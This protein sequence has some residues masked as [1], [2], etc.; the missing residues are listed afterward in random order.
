MSTEKVTETT[1]FGAEGET[2]CYSRHESLQTCQQLLD[3]N[4]KL[5]TERDQY[6]TTMD[7]VYKELA[8]SRNQVKI[9]TEEREKLLVLVE[10]IERLLTK[11][12]RRSLNLKLNN[13]VCYSV[14]K[15]QL[16]IK[17]INMAPIVFSIALKAW[18]S[19]IVNIACHLAPKTAVADNRKAIRN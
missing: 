12:V 18:V 2:E 8:D 9:L 19:F 5:R 6:K 1:N 16:S 3:E 14:T 17:S 13:V 4:T 10:V 7:R 15:I 11:Q